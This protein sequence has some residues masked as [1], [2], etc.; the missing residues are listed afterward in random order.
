MQ[1]VRVSVRITCIPPPL[2]QPAVPTVS[3]PIASTLPL[4]HCSC[5]ISV[6]PFMT[7]SHQIQQVKQPC[8]V[9]LPPS[10]EL[11]YFRVGSPG[12]GA[13]PRPGTICE[14]NRVSPR[15]SQGRYS[16]A[17][18]KDKTDRQTCTEF[19]DNITRWSWLKGHPNDENSVNRRGSGLSTR[20][21][22]I[23]VHKRLHLKPS[24]DG[25]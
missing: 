5:T 18:P 14:P 13:A 8:R 2:A 22:L 16:P 10:L 7:P 3:L 1:E 24:Y 23:K 19:K 17:S 15:S 21:F 4:R 6:K 25:K 11:A 9:R 12:P 20:P